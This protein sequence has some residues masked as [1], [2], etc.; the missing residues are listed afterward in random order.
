MET[1][2]ALDNA[3]LRDATKQKKNLNLF[4]QTEILSFFP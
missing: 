1:L 4:N 2:V 3:K